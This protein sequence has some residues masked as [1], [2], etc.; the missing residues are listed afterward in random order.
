MSCD[1]KQR[2]GGAG[3]SESRLLLIEVGV[4]P[5]LVPAPLSKI[6]TSGKEK[7]KS[8]YTVSHA[9]NYQSGEYD[10]AV[11]YASTES[12]QEEKNVWDLYG[13]YIEERYLRTQGE[14]R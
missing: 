12:A 2:V 5:P 3:R 4:D 8:D 10:H 11:G 9:H 14:R 13:T 7:G 1:L 6:G